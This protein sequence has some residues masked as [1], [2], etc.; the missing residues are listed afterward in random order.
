MDAPPRSDRPDVLL[1]MT[2]Q[3]RTGFT[4]RTGCPLDTMPTLDRLAGQGTA[5][6]LA[7]TSYP[8]CVPARTSLLTGR[9]P[10]AHRVRQNS[11]AEHAYY[12]QDLLDVL[13]KQGYR[14]S[15][16][17]KPHMHPGPADFDHYAGPYMHTTGP[18]RTEQDA[19]FDAWLD[20]LDHGVADRPTPFPLETQLPYRITSD[21]IAAI[22]AAPADQPAFWWV[23]FPEPHNP[24]QVPEPYFDLF[25]PEAVPDRWAGP[26]SIEAKG[27]GYRWLRRLVEEK[28]PGY[29]DHWRRYRSNYLGMLRLID[30]QLARLLD[31]LGPRL[32]NTVVIFVSDHGDYLGDY[33]LQRK[34]AGLSEALTRIPFQF[35]GPG[36]AGGAVR[37]EPVS[38]VD[39][40]PTLCELVGAEI[41]AGV[42]G[43]SLLPL[44]AGEPSPEQEF[45]SMIVELGYGGVPY[46]DDDR[47]P[48]HFDYSGPQFDE[49]NSVT[50]SGGARM[51]RRGD[52]KLIMD[53]D[54]NGELYDLRVDPAELQNRFLDPE[55]A[56]VREELTRLLLR[57]TIR[58]ADDLPAGTYRPKTAEHNW[59][60]AG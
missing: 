36:I 20:D 58:V 50:Q 35:T 37:E 28:R 56:A 31:H 9:F 44:L 43:R 29:D 53:V 38:L 49:L 21:A 11:N 1:I 39:V 30:D 6:D 59:R 12:Q 42:Q 48:L 33:G 52:H 51:I 4:R 16:S 27:R 47:P 5:F 32:E 45:S 25:P 15:F 41:P 13:R 17:G 19:A 10:T 7:Y 23:S 57:W 26:E 2:D 8:A 24:Y 55:L 46:S 22:D 14:L 3:H 54:G 34:G 18:E 40:L 60:W